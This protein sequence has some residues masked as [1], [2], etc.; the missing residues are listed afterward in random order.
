MKNRSSFKSRRKGCPVTQLQPHC[1]TAYKLHPALQINLSWMSLFKDLRCL[2]VFGNLGQ[3]ICLGPCSRLAAE[4]RLG[5]LGPESWVIA[6]SRAWHYLLRTQIKL[7][8][9][10]AKLGYRHRMNLGR[11]YTVHSIASVLGCT[12]FKESK[13][14]PEVRH[15]PLC[16]PSLGKRRDRTAFYRCDR[17]LFNT[18]MDCLGRH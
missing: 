16:A 10:T 1:R 14:C 7:T 8:T 17:H 2:S 9:V 18:S 5:I 13:I 12:Q 4:P 15:L 6:L 11:L 3:V